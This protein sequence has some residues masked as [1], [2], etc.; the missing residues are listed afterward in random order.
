MGT[1][2]SSVFML[3]EIDLVLERALKASQDSGIRNFFGWCSIIL[4][5]I[6]TYVKGTLR[7]SRE[8][9]ADLYVGLPQ[10]LLT[11]LIEPHI[12]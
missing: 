2:P 5:V 3:F 9:A 8:G 12:P 1:V 6:W 4:Q 10:N 11:V 7:N